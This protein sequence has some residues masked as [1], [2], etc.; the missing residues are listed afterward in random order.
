M[1]G[2]LNVRDQPTSVHPTSAAGDGATNDTAAI[3][4]RDHGPRFEPASGASAPSSRW[5]ALVG[6]GQPGHLWRRQVGGTW[7]NVAR[8]LPPG[9][10]YEYGGRAVG[11]ARDTA[12]AEYAALSEGD[13]LFV[14]R[15]APDGPDDASGWLL[16]GGFTVV[17]FSG[18]SLEQGMLAMWAGLDG[19]VRLA[20]PV[21]TNPR[22][23]VVFARDPATGLWGEEAR[24]YGSTLSAGHVFGLRAVDGGVV[25]AGGPLP[26]REVV[27]VG[28]PYRVEPYN[29]AG[30]V[31]LFRREPTGA[32]VEEAALLSASGIHNG[33]GLGLG[34]SGSLLAVDGANRF[35]TVVP[36]GSTPPW[37]E[38]GW[39]EITH[40]Y[41][42]NQR[43]MVI[44]GR[45]LVVGGF[46]DNDLGFQA[47]AAWVFTLP[48]SLT[49]AEPPP[50]PAGLALAAPARHPVRGGATVRYTQPAPAA[51]TLTL[52]DALGREV[53]R[54]AAPAQPAG[55]H[56]V[57]LD[58]RALAAGVYVLRHAAGGSGATQRMVVA[59]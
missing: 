14:F 4:G 5:L 10:T 1:D 52:H 20:F 55:A 44:G 53:W 29:Q 35:W 34:L 9:N 37:A 19:A 59:R 25:A 46:V 32:W 11:L 40:A 27:A 26:E 47:G 45:Y 3:Q 15:R 42:A 51:A 2:Y 12:G 21:A 18:L 16:E 17:P 39:A 58:A 56:A 24:L 33:F 49:P 22:A 6:G 31:Y 41:D 57:P 43:S 30:Q 48:G 36:T 28:A 23:V 13:S 7:T 54:H 50:A 38:S 8:F